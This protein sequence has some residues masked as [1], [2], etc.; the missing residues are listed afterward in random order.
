MTHPLLARFGSEPCLVS[1]DKKDWFES[2]LNAI[3]KAPHADEMLNNVYA[4]EDGFWPAADHWTAAYRPYVVRDGILQIPV[5][6][7]L[8]HDFSFAVGSYATGYIYIA[9][10]LARGIADDNVRGIALVC[11]SPGG[12]VAGNFE[13]VDKIFAARSSKPIRAFAHESAYSAAYSIA[14]AANEIAVS[15]TG[16]VGS[17]GVV[18]YHMDLSA[19]MEDAGIKVTFIYAGKYKV[20]G[21][22]YEA[23]P[24][25]AKDRMQKRIDQLYS[26]FVSSV[27][28]NRAMDEEAVRAT[29]A[30]CYSADDAISVGLADSVASFDDAVAAFAAD[31][32]A[33]EEEDEMAEA[34]A[35][36][37]VQA[38]HEAAI[39]SLN[40]QHATA[41]TTARAEGKAE[42]AAEMQT[43]CKTIL[44]AEEAKGRTEQ[45]TYLA[46]ETDMPVDKAVGLLNASPKM[47]TAVGEASATAKT[48]GEVMA[49][50]GNPNVNATIG[51]DNQTDD[52]KAL[53]FV[54]GIFN[55]TKRSA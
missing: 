31:L 40:A 49:A 32:T 23:L 22:A 30:L 51:D 12:H 1:A 10:A 11:D 28:R 21:N 36:Q 27:A 42:G 8:L 13:L 2:C 3:V 18:T 43:R 44:N 55:A 25:D 48:F 41:L 45:A 9:R 54:D 20:E 24:K 5:K 16:G 19:A 39:A 4:S 33:I 7:V 15:R 52:A 46:L 37:T 26:V 17:I 35:I 38:N 34:N 6:G 47:L 50:N 29:E 53:A 14:S